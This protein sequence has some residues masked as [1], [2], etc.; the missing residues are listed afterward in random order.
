MHNFR[1]WSLSSAVV[2]AMVSACAQRVQPPTAD[3]GPDQAVNEGA[4]VKLNGSASADH[5]GRPL[6]Y[7]WS[8]ASRP[9]SS[10]ATLADANTVAPSFQA[11]ASGDFVVQL[12]VSNSVLVSNA[13]TV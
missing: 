2:L 10:T 6:A 3:A 12:V 1:R 4:F 7:Q 5:Q 13:A 9:P 8:F 11:D